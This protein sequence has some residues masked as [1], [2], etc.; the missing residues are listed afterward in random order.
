MGLVGSNSLSAGAISLLNGGPTLRRSII[1]L[2]AIF[3]VLSK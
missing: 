1:L 3:F 2:F